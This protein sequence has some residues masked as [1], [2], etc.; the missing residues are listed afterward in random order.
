MEKKREMYEQKSEVLLK[1][2]LSKFYSLEANYLE[3]KMNAH[4]KLNKISDQLPDW[5]EQL[6]KLQEKQEKLTNFY[7]GMMASSQEAWKETSKTLG[8]STKKLDESRQNFTE[9]TQGWL[10]SMGE[11]ITKLEERTEH[12]SGE[13]REQLQSRVNH[14]KTQQTNLQLKIKEL[15]QTTGENW[16]K[17]NSSISDEVNAMTTSIDKF[18]QHLFASENN[19][20]DEK[21]A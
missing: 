14:L 9:R 5:E 11:W 3:T 8:K 13:F 10:N 21:E 20:I 12:S 15:Q 2:L 17:I 1:R 16:D 19:K 7:R 18:Y 4:K 6:E